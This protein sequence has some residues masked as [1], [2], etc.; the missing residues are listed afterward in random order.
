MLYRNP[1]CE[2]LRTKLWEPDKEQELE[3]WVWTFKMSVPNLFSQELELLIKMLKNSLLCQKQL[4]LGKKVNMLIAMHISSS[5]LQFSRV[6]ASCPWRY[7]QCWL[8]TFQTFLVILQSTTQTMSSWL[9]ACCALLIFL[10]DF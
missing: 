4:Q 7:V 3:V 1:C 10:R 6:S 8:K 5:A 2:Q 9:N